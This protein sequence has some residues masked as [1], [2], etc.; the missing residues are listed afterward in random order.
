MKKILFSAALCAATLAS[1]GGDKSGMT[2]GSL[3]QFDSLSYALGANMGY[4]INYQMKD[5]PSTSRPSTAV[6]ARPLRRRA[7]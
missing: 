6:S 4:G 5:I 3:S 1:C 2:M 7:R